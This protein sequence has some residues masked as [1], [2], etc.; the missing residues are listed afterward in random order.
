MREGNPQLVLHTTAR[1][2]V[3]GLIDDNVTPAA[4]SSSSFSPLSK[5]IDI[6]LDINEDYTRTR[7]KRALSHP[8]RAAHF[9]ITLGPGRGEEQVQMPNECDFQWAEYERID[10]SAVLAGKHGASSYCVRKG[11]S[12]K[13]QLAHFTRL[14]VCKNPDSILKDTLPQTVVLDTWPV[15][16]DNCAGNGAGLADIVIGS[17]S[18]GN[19]VNRRGRLDKCLEEART[20]IRQ[21]EATYDDEVATNADTSPPIWILKPSTINKGAGIQIVHCYEQV[22]DICWSESDIREWYVGLT[23]FAL[24]CSCRVR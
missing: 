22:V 9:H 7:I 20:M 4:S 8:S 19:G 17:T 10:W 24:S 15:W 23:G 16:E 1:F 2:Q 21:A 11:I 12:R 6:F 3:L 13:A 18:N 14:Y 5:K